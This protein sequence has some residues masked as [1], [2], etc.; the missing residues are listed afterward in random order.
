MP[1]RTAFGTKRIHHSSGE[2]GRSR[3]RFLL[4]QAESI[5]LAIACVALA[6]S[7]VLHQ[8]SLTVPTFIVT[9]ACLAVLA[10]LVGDGTEQ[11]S[12]RLGP[13]A[14]GVLQSA[15]GNLPELF[16]GIFAL[17]AGLVGVVQ[18]A[19]V[20]SILGNSLLVLG[21]AFTVGGLRNGTQKFNVDAPR[22][23]ATLTILAV[24]AIAIPTLAGQFHTPAA[25]HV[26]AL[27]VACAVV[28]LLVFAAGIPSSLRGGPTSFGG[29]DELAS[30][31]P[32]WLA[33]LVMIFASVA[34]AFVSD[35]FVTALMPA[36]AALHLSQ[37]FTGLVIVA[38]AGNA[39][40]NVVGVQL[41][42]RNEP[43]YG[44]SVILNSSLQ[45]ALGLIPALVLLSY[46]IGAPIPLTL[47][48]PPLLVAALLLAAILGPL[49]VYDGEST[50]LEGI[51]LIGLYV[52][53]AAGFWWG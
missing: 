19:L 49:I 28:L 50:W 38:L 40:E 4:S 43:N 39:V 44:I 26:E 1:R 21:L 34:A 31:W 15:L 27:S 23:I 7:F 6:F 47:V 18:A 42:A 36:T 30:V 33:V 29:R 11:L 16:I 46:V 24:S 41:M 20:G 37:T 25:S 3:R 5:K 13:G 17:R 53:I 22:A 35:W 9:A 51:S 8:T 2:P 10:T 45:V 32:V 52:I 48:L 12:S 14:T